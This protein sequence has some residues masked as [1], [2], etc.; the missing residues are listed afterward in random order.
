MANIQTYLNKIKNAIYGR[1]VRDSIHDAIDA[2]NTESENTKDIIEDFVGG[3]LDTT[4]TSTTLPAQGKA[5]GDAVDDLKSQI[6]ALTTNENPNYNNIIDWDNILN[7]KLMWNAGTYQDN[8]GYWSTGYIPIKPN[9]Q[10]IKYNP[11]RN[12]YPGIQRLHFFDANKNPVSGDVWNDN[13]VT[14][15]ANASYMVISKRYVHSGSNGT[16]TGIEGWDDDIGEM[17]INQTDEGNFHEPYPYYLNDSIH[18]RHS[19][20][21]TAKVHSIKNAIKDDSSRLMINR[22]L[23]TANEE[24]SIKIC[25]KNIFDGVTQDGYWN[26]TSVVTNLTHKASVNPIYTNGG[27]YIVTTANCRVT[28]FTSDGSY[29][30]SAIAVSRTPYLISDNTDYFH[31]SSE[32][33]NMENMCVYIGTKAPD[34][35]QAYKETVV[36]HTVRDW[37]FTVYGIEIPLYDGDNTV[38]VNKNNAPSLE[39]RYNA[40]IKT[41]NSEFVNVQKSVDSICDFSGIK[42]A[43]S[44]KYTAHRGSTLQAPENTTYA[45]VQAFKNGFKNVEID[46]RMTSDNVPVLLHDSTIDRTSNGSGAVS[47]MTLAEL[48]TYDFGSWFG[49]EFAG[50]KIP[51]L[52]QAC[53]LCRALNIKP[54]LDIAGSNVTETM[55]NAICDILKRYELLDG[56]VFYVNG[57]NSGAP[58]FRAYY[59]NAGAKYYMYYQVAGFGDN[60]IL[61]L[62]N[63][64]NQTFRNYDMIYDVGISANITDMSSAVKEAALGYER[65]IPIAVYFVDSYTD[66]QSVQNYPYALYC[67]NR[68]DIPNFAAQY[69]APRSIWT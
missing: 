44:N 29:N 21:S 62:M 14:T 61:T 15:P 6:D 66:Y 27:N 42:M 60:S 28:E 39:L 1:D 2:I 22:S 19:V 32:I 10:Y 34:T 55:A 43:E 68:G 26:G 41:L 59:E 5:V 56:A 11:A 38:Y 4:L 51:T 16:Y 18:V 36:T 13:R 3:E 17:V 52:D 12:T 58:Y 48:Q 53:R 9:T 33:E 65:R 25:G 40:N 7:G 63:N 37:G 67:T 8:E 20:N 23:F 30:T 69:F 47:S 31:I 54:H 24:I 45:I 57:S 46:V 35:N 50:T 64:I 49:K